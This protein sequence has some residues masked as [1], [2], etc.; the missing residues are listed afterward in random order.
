MGTEPCITRGKGFLSPGLWLNAG[1]FSPV[2][3]PA[4]VTVAQPTDFSPVVYAFKGPG[5]VHFSSVDHPIVELIKL[6]WL[7]PPSDGGG[8]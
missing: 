8:G 5:L 6:A 2:N 1:G 7:H 4:G 3:K